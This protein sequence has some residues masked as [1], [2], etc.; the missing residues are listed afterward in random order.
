MNPIFHID[1]HGLNEVARKN[2]YPI[3]HVDDT[4]DEPKDANFHTHLDL[5]SAPAGGAATA[6][7]EG[8][9]LA[10]PSASPHLPVVGAWNPAAVPGLAR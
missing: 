4:L 5:A 3:P 10:C 2:A 1:Y 7:P 8:G 9:A 6:A